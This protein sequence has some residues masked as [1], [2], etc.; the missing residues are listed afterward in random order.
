MKRTRLRSVSR[1]TRAVRWPALAALRLHV[2]MRATWQCEYVHAYG[3]WHHGPLE[4]H[5][6][7][8]RSRLRNDSPDN[9]VLLCLRHHQDTDR[10]YAI[11]RLVVTPLGSGRFHFEIVTKA[12]KWAAR[13]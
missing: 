10:P 5:H 1:K 9:A 7:V 4:V 3:G 13:G 8:K 11:G 12:D 2:G 6:V